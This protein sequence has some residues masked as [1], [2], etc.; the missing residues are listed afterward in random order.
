[1]YISSALFSLIITICIIIGILS[2][3]LPLFL[4]V[5][6]SKI[7]KTLKIIYRQLTDFYN[8]YSNYK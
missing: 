1:M 5:Y 6:L 7:H 4:I 2:C 8:K 3:L